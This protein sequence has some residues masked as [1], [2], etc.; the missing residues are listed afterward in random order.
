M[1]AVDDM[2]K[3]NIYNIV[4]NYRELGETVQEPLALGCVT[5]KDL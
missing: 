1:E 2:T 5:V 4:V 3:N